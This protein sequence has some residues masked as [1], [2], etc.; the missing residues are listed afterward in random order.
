MLTMTHNREYVLSADQS[1]YQ[2]ALSQS[3]NTIMAV[4][5]DQLDQV[6]Y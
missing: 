4:H 1:T 2:L 5:R 6:K 3:N